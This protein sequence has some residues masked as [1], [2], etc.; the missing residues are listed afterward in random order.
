MLFGQQSSIL[1]QTNQQ[2]ENSE[3]GPTNLMVHPMASNSFAEKSHSYHQPPQVASSAEK[4]RRPHATLIGQGADSS[5][6]ER[7]MVLATP[8][9]R[10]ENKN[11]LDRSGKKKETKPIN[12]QKNDGNRALEVDSDVDISEG[13]SAD[14]TV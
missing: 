11:R 13:I 8:G 10:A 3:N 7:Q 6:S 9:A 2:N 5:L 14:K 12:V 1:Q 4:V